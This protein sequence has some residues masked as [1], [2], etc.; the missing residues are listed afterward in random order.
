MPANCKIFTGLDTKSEQ[1]Y[2]MKRRVLTHK[3]DFDIVDRMV[4]HT[5]DLDDTVHV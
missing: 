5:N 4:I 3:H 2:N 1:Y